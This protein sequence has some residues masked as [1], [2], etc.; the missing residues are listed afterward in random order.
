MVFRIQVRQVVL[1][2]LAAQSAG[3]QIMVVQEAGTQAI[4]LK[5]VDSYGFAH[6]SD[7]RNLGSLAGGICEH[8]LADSDGNYAFFGEAWMV[9][10]PRAQEVWPRQAM[11]G[12]AAAIGEHDELLVL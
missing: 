10:Y 11:S 5:P 3:D 1:L 9:A 7:L 4:P 12:T 8:R 2:P 6:G